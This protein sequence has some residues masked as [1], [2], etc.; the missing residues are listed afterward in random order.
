VLLP[1]GAKYCSFKNDVKRKKKINVP[2]HMQMKKPVLHQLKE[3]CTA[4][5][6]ILDKLNAANKIKV[7]EISSKHNTNRDTKK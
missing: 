5:T 3:T 1:L 4:F 6:H 7:Q 2:K